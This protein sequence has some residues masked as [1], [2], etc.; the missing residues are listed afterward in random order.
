MQRRCVSVREARSSSLIAS[1]QKIRKAV[2][3]FF[4]FFYATADSAIGET[5]S[6][7][8]VMPTPLG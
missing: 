7:I 3:R 1:G 2:F 5:R 8:I 6:S 4:L